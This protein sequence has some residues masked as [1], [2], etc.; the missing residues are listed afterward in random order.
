MSDMLP[1]SQERLIVRAWCSL[2]VRCQTS[3][4][5]LLTW[6]SFPRVLESSFLLLCEDIQFSRII[7]GKDS[8]FSKICLSVYL[9]PMCTLSLSSDTLEEGIRS[10]YR[11]L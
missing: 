9:M 7:C 5:M 10:H 11:W 3:I 2:E 8:F 1:I 4:T 6:V